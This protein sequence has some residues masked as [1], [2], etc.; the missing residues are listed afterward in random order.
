MKYII[1]EQLDHESL[2]EDVNKKLDEGW[3]PQGG[4]SMATY[5]F[6]DPRR[7]YEEIRDYYCQA[8]VRED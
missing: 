1:I 2:I 7:D 3:K 4:V 8:L 6:K 5:I